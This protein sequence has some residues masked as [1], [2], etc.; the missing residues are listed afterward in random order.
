MRSSRSL[1]LL[2]HQA[3]GGP[4]PLRQKEGPS[5]ARSA[6]GKDVCVHANKPRNVY[7]E[8]TIAC[9]L[10]CRHCRAEAIGCRDPEELTGSEAHRLIESVAELGSMLIFTGGDPMERPDLFELIEYAREQR[11]PVGVTPSTTPKLNENDVCRLADH[12]VAAM[13][14]SL[15]GASAATHDVFR[16]FP[17]T[18]ERARQV[19]GW[20]AKYKIPVQVNTTVTGSNIGELQAIYELLST[21]HAPPVKRW[22]LFLLV[23]TGRAQMS[24]LP[25]AEHM[26][27]VYA[28]LYSLGRNSP[29]HVG[30]IEAPMY[31]RYLVQ[32]GL[33]EGSTWGEILS[34]SGRYGLGIR[35]G[36]GVV[37]VSHKGRV[38][39]SGFVPHTP[40]GNVK[41]TPLHEL[42]RHAPD[43]AVLRDMDRL[44]GKC[45]RC[46]YRWVCGGSRARAAAVHGHMM[47]EEPLCAYEPSGGEE[48]EAR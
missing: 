17:G 36:N 23:P 39:P 9:S 37:F 43:L 8:T 47:A 22:S 3:V 29:F 13:G 20:A 11:V 27:E 4:Y 45:G 14:V 12:G 1:P 15:D 38:L 46:E 26:E 25:G 48:E 16:G 7:W 19:L 42:Y 30:T 6:P 44:D 24:D 41:E 32:Q 5:S 21:Y 18:F 28:W 34:H 35:D 40:L 31:R 33:K 2:P 10:A